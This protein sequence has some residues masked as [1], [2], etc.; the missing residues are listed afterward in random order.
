MLLYQRAMSIP[1]EDLLIGNLQGETPAWQDRIATAMASAPLLLGDLSKLSAED[2]RHSSEWIARFHKLRA[3][4][5]LE[6]SFFPL[7]AWRQTRTDAWDGYARFAKTGEGMIVIFRNESAD[8]TAKIAI[9]GFPDGAFSV[10]DWQSGARK[11]LDGKAL[12]NGW[13][14]ATEGKPRVLVLEVRKQ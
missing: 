12:R 1:T 5:R 3:E 14:F 9:P 2:L 8:A 10:T 6:E 13:E 11:S 4:V 7:G